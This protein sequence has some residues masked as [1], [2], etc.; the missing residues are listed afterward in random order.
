M[1]GPKLT[2]ADVQNVSWTV[3]EVTDQYR[4]SIGHGTHPVTG[5]PITVE[6][7][8]ALVEPELIELNKFLRNERD[9]TR[10]SAGTGSEKGGNVPFVHVARTPLNK[11]LA[12]H[13][14]AEQQGDKDFNRWWLNR[15]ENQVFRTRNGTV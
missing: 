14:E 1:K 3:V 15:E 10:W 7:T 8:E 4:R 2:E 9:G 5:V 12:D 11:W 6:R 13:A